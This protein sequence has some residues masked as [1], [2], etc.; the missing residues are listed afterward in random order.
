MEKRIGRPSLGVT[1]KVSLTASEDV[2]LFVNTVMYEHDMSQSEA[3]RYIL[4]DA[5]KGNQMVMEDL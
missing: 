2:W 5:M 4:E 1:K 3:L